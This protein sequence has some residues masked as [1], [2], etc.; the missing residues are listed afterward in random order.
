MSTTVTPT[1]SPDLEP[2]AE[3]DRKSI[4]R[5]IAEHPHLDRAAAHPQPGGEASDV[6]EWYCHLR[7]FRSVRFLAYVEGATRGYG[8][9]PPCRSVALLLKESED[10]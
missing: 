4:G 7:A 1:D 8:P 2:V 5:R 10:G 3:T 6:E 9:P